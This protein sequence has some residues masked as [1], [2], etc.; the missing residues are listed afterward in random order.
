MRNWTSEQ[1]NVKLIDLCLIKIL[2]QLSNESIRSWTKLDFQS[3]LSTRIFYSIWKQKWSS[4]VH[5]AFEFTHLHQNRWFYLKDI[6]HQNS[7]QARCQRESLFYWKDSYCLCDFQT[8]RWC[9]S[10]NLCKASCWCFLILSVTIR[11]TETSERN[12]RRSES[13]LKVSLQIRCSEAAQQVF[14]LFL[15]RIH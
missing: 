8:R 12:L 3:S 11:V 4:Q 6:K 7:W 14:Q 15:F 1:N 10:A 9:W 5:Q 13:D 2:S